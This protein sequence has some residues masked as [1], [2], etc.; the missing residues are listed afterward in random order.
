MIR[1]DGKCSGE[2]QHSQFHVPVVPK[3]GECRR[4][5]SERL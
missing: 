5:G 4:A 3:P 2:I 1:S